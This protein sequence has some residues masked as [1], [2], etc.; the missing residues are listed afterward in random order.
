MGEDV[1][2]VAW[3]VGSA[4]WGAF[5]QVGLEPSV[6]WWKMVHWCDAFIRSQLAAW[7][8]ASL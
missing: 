8:M 5:A 3:E 7:D 4:P 6:Y 1:G 2:S